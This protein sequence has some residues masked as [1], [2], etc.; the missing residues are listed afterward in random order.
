MKNH[1]K[2]FA[3]THAVMLALVLELPRSF[4]ATLFKTKQKKNQNLVQICAFVF[5][6]W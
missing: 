6:Q 4:F 5:D 2:V 1:I 3:D